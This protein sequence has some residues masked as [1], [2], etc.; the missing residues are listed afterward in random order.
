M[1]VGASFQAPPPQHF[2]QAPAVPLVPIPPYNPNAESPDQVLQRLLDG[3]RRFIAGQ[4]IHPHQEKSRIIELCSGQKPFASILSCADSR[5]PCEIVFDAGFGD[6]FIIRVAGNIA[7]PEQ[8]ASLEYSILELGVKL[9][10]IL[11]HTKCGAVKAALKGERLPGFLEALI[12]Q[13][14]VAIIRSGNSNASAAGKISPQVVEQVVRENTLYQLERCMR[15]PVIS[16][17]IKNGTV[18]VV[19]AMYD[20]ESGNVTLIRV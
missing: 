6:V 20:L 17:A 12:D 7:A 18:K 1:G 13:I 14:D 16:E 9:I 4:S 19:G 2:V 3:N 8:V 11:G 5:V 15:S 10:V